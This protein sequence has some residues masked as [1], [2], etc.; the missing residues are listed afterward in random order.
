MAG[1]FEAFANFSKGAA[2]AF[3]RYTQ[4]R[5]L[6]EDKRI[7]AEQR[8]RED[9]YRQQQLALQQQQFGLQAD[10]NA[11]A[12]ELADLTRQQLSQA[13]LER[14]VAMFEGMHGPG[15]VVDAPTAA[16]GRELGLGGRI[17][18]AS[19]ALRPAGMMQLPGHTYTLN[20][21]FDPTVDD[22]DRLESQS[23]VEI[24]DAPTTLGPSFR[25]PQHA[26]GT[27]IYSGSPEQ[28]RERQQQ[29]Q[30]ALLADGLDPINAAA[31]MTGKP[32]TRQPNPSNPPGGELG[33]LMGLPPDQ[34]QRAMGIIGQK[35][36]L[37][38]PNTGTSGGSTPTADLSKLPP[39]VRDIITRATYRLPGTRKPS[40]IASLAEAYTAD[41]DNW[42]SFIQQA[43]VEGEGQAQQDLLAGRRAL[44]NQSDE[45]EKLFGEMQQAG[46]PTDWFSGTAESLKRRLGKSGNPKYVE[47]ATRAGMA[48]SD[49]I[50]SI[51]GA[52]FTD[53][54]FRRYTDRWPSLTNEAEVNFDILK[55][56]RGSMK[57]SDDSYWNFKLGPENYKLLRAPFVG[58][59]PSGGLHPF[60]SKE[61]LDRFNALIAQ[62][63]A[64][65]R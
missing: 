40:A 28:I 20:P 33:Y 63:P 45:L 43:A 31:L 41:P 11:R 44:I 61:E 48:L 6:R 17:N 60:D 2:P 5:E 29:L 4:L 18:P 13:L 52:A 19:Q 23:M 3:D 7:A 54:E 56:L 21:D 16:S 9:Q 34:L 50:R 57:T 10:A 64:G 51:S 47:F 1:W 53:P 15:E 12:G 14:R 25:L 46:V 26:P 62:P 27:A 8:L 32:L 30:L 24:P 36:R 59:D 55:A 22:R 58:R 49:Y 38:S 65:K 39:Q 42:R 37:T 35:D